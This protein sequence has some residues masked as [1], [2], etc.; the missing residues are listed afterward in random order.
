MRAVRAAGSSREPDG[1]YLPDLAAKAGVR[2]TRGWHAAGRPARWEPGGRS[3]HTRAGTKPS[4]AF[5]SVIWLTQLLS[6]V[7]DKS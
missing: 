1:D 4:R 7:I 3:H 5:A 6:T 2:R